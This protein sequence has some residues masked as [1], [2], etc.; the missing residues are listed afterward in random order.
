MYTKYL[1]RRYIP[2]S[3]RPEWTVQHAY[4]K[5]LMDA[6]FTMYF[7]SIYMWKQTEIAS[8]FNNKIMYS[9][10]IQKKNIILYSICHG[11]NC[12]LV[13]LAIVKKTPPHLACVLL[14]IT[15]LHLYWWNLQA[16]E[17][18]RPSLPPSLPSCLLQLLSMSI[19]PLLRITNL[20]IN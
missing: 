20:L 1:R 3:T 8:L 2:N 19:T 16:Y 5:S 7:I 17:S 4:T 18:V 6:T 14:Q 11:R 12:D 10:S 15:T 13:Q 9:R